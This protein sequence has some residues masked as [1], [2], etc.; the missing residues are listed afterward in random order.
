MPNYVVNNKIKPEILA[1]AGS[2]ESLKTAISFGA[3]A[4]Y[5][6]YKDFSARAKAENFDDNLLLKAVKYAHFYRVRVY[7]AL[8]TLV[9]DEELP[10]VYNAIDCVYN[11]GVDAIIVQD[12]KI[13]KY[14][15]QHYPNLSVHFST[16]ASIHNEYAAIV[17]KKL[18]ADRIILSRE[19]TIED[20]KRIKNNCDIEIECF[21]H[22]ALCVSFSGNC[23]FSSLVSGY[24]GNRGKC[25]QLCRK[26]YKIDGKEGYYLSPK[27][28]CCASIIDELIEAGVSSFKIEGR[29]RRSEYVG[30]VVS[31][32]RKILDGKKYSLDDVKLMYNR[33]DYTQVHL[34]NPTNNVIYPYAQGHIGLKQGKVLSINGK[35]AKLSCSLS[36]GDAVKF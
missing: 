15:K 17:A 32:Y 27:D 20:I 24:S 14:I 11:C 19:V 23:Y 8:N 7:L 34:K 3:D 29:M 31:L 30:S 9:L 13:I 18:G 6:G 28:I 2:F 1:P 26:K 4:V 33:G 21:V 36:V 25:L 16:Q 12:L 5:L 10:S 35:F 22:G